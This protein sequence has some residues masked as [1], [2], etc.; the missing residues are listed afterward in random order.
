MSKRRL[1]LAPST[2]PLPTKGRARRDERKSR[3]TLPRKDVP[4]WTDL[5]EAFFAAAPPDEPVGRERARAVRRPGSR[6]ADARRGAAAAADLRRAPAPGRRRFVDRRASLG[7]RDEAADRVQDARVGVRLRDAGCLSVRGRQRQRVIAA[8]D[9]QR[10][11]AAPT[12]ARAPPP[13]RRA[14]TADRANPAAEATACADRPAPDRAAPRW[15]RRAAG[16]RSRSRRRPVLPA[17]GGSRPARPWT[18]RPGTPAPCA[19]ARS[20]FSA[21]RWASMSAGSRSGRLRPA[22]MYG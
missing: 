8:F 9:D 2:R 6:R 18:C 4:V 5:E 13:D 14:G 20:A 7:R 19:R 16:T 11:C 12:S 10:R 17:P 1:A 21:W 22:S 15:T 3:G